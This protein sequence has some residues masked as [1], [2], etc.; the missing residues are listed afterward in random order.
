MNHRSRNKRV[1]RH[2]N[3]PSRKR[4]LFGAGPSRG[5]AAQVVIIFGCF[6][7]VGFLGIV[8]WYLKAHHQGI[9]Q[10]ASSS[11]SVV[12]VQ[13][14]AERLGNL[15]QQ[16]REESMR[17]LQ[18]KQQQAR[19]EGTEA[20]G[21]QTGVKIIPKNLLPLSSDPDAYRSPLLIFTCKRPAYLSQTLDDILKNIGDHCAFGCPVVVSEDGASGL[22]HSERIPS[23]L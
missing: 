19:S 20:P 4:S 16:R 11:S 2:N 3:T 23:L 12:G 14:L 18:N 10:P 15:R 5:I 6:W 7:I 8:I 13:S 1:T 17:F 22:T 9:G 21:P